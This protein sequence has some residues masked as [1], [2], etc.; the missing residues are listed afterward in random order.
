MLTNNRQIHKIQLIDRLIKIKKK[1]PNAYKC[2]RHIYY[3]KFDHA[4]IMI[5]TK[6]MLF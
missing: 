3:T 6:Q 4:S 1:L 5:K 2:D